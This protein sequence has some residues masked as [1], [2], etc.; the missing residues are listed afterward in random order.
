MLDLTLDIGKDLTGVTFEPVAV[1][2]FG[3]DSELND[4]VSG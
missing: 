1:E 2:G 3:H 4:E